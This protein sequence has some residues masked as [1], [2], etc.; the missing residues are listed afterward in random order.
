MGNSVS[1]AGNTRNAGKIMKNAEDAKFLP[2]KIMKW[3]V[4]N[5][6]F[7]DMLDLTD[8]SKCP[9]Y[10]EE[11]M[12]LVRRQQ[13]QQPPLI[14]DQKRFHD[15]LCLNKSFYYATLFQ[16]FGA[17]FL[18]VGEQ[19][20]FSQRTTDKFRQQ[21][22]QI[23]GG[24]RTRRKSKR[25][26]VGG[27]LTRTG[28]EKVYDK[29]IRTPFAKILLPL[30]SFQRSKSLEEDN[31]ILKMDEIGGPGYFYIKWD[32]SKAN[33]TDMTLQGFYQPRAKSEEGQ[34]YEPI[35]SSVRMYITGASEDSRKLI[36]LKINNEYFA[37][38]VET[39]LNDTST[40][41]FF[42]GDETTG[43]V[44]TDKKYLFAKIHEFFKD[45]IPE[46]ASYSTSTSS[47]TGRT[48]YTSSSSS[49][50]S[51]SSFSKTIPDFRKLFDSF[52]KGETRMPKAYAIARAMTLIT[53]LYLAERETD[54]E[55]FF[56]NVCN[57]AENVGGVKEDYA[58]PKPGKTPRDNI[59]LRSLV[60]LFYDEANLVDST[61]TAVKVELRKSP[62][63]DADLKNAST[64]LARLYNIPTTQKREE[65]IESS[66]PFNTYGSKLCADNYRTNRAQITDPQVIELLQKYVIGPMIKLQ[67]EHNAQ[68]DEFI[69]SMV[70]MNG[71]QIS[72]SPILLAE[73]NTTERIQINNCRIRAREIILHYYL[74]SEAFFIL[75]ILLL[76]KYKAG[77][78]LRG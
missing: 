68:V 66:T 40:L 21:Q 53:P 43:P 29:I 54:T 1:S 48:T 58:M 19:V 47:T 5:T 20:P 28:N 37:S 59:Y 15:T 32:S 62:S 12:K 56:C 16:I 57:M 23:K 38:F 33:S 73:L 4:N 31:L 75:G 52:Y 78:T 72:L 25:S 46:T 55:P 77:T 70:S 76:E 51:S 2:D 11:G 35:Q 71:D 6:E 74:K 17:L 41:R 63:A 8:I 36:R 64:L 7:R 27:A 3:I 65:F 69:K 18:T 49:S 14:G 22:R 50:I 34:E 9:Y 13:V 24:R 44:Y 60:G 10:V 30:F 61:G 39:M 26:Q 67:Q 45:K 42:L